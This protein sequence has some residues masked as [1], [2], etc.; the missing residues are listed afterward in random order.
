MKCNP[1]LDEFPTVSE[2]VKAIKLLSFGKAPESDA[3]HAE[4]YKAGGPLVAE[5]LTELFPIMWRKE[6]IPQKRRVHQLSTYSNG[7]SSGHLFIVSFWE[8]PCKSPTEP[9]EF[10]P[11]TWR[12]EAIPQKRKVHQL[13]T[14]SNG[15]SSGHLFIVSFWEDPCKSPTGPME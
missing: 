12:K 6:A 7:Q 5:E 11:I 8:D 4:I 9:I 15:Q 1:L 10:F 3:I 13:S 14:Y 2:I